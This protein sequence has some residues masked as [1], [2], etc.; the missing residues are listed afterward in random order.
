M[1]MKCWELRAGSDSFA[2]LQR[3]ERDVPRP[4]AGQVLVKMEA[5][6]LNYRDLM[7][8]D[9][10]YFRGPV[11]Q[12]VIPLSDG[13]GTVVEV[14]PNVRGLRVGERVVVGFFQV[15]SNE[16]SNAPAKA[17]GAPLDGTLCEYQVFHEQGLVRA[18]SN[19]DARQA[20]TLPCAGLTAWNALLGGARPAA[21]GDTV[22]TLGTGG[23]SSFVILLG[24]ALGAR[25][26]VTSSSEEKLQRAREIG[27]ADGVNY[28]MN[29][30]WDEAILQLT[31]G[32]GA[33]CIVENGGPGTLERSLKCL[34]HRGKIAIVGVLAG[35]RAPP[36]VMPLLMKRGQMHG[37]YVGEREELQAMVRAVEV[38]GI[39]P[40]IDRVFEFEDAVAA[41]EYQSRGLHF[42]KVV[43]SIA[44]RS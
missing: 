36:S 41:Y 24:R 14:G 25:V 6:A 37:V 20:A 38:N 39:E 3:V 23:V 9:G 5:A 16:P 31:Q 26:L 18:P 22:L 15:P 10:R 21:L 27:A 19:L 40:I 35:D 42:G 44:Q 13:A 12:S 11:R 7:V 4:M 34:A 2:G 30:A 32:T 8:A 43:I 29:P 17:L 28:R 1:T 33:D